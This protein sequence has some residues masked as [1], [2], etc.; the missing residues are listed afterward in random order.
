MKTN[1]TIVISAVIIALALVFSGLSI[2]SAISL[3][4]VNIDTATGK[5]LLMNEAEASE[6]IGIEV[7]AFNN[8]LKEDIKERTNLNVYPTYKFVPYMVIEGNKYFN[9]IELD[10]WVEFNMNNK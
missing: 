9:K 8:I 5:N 3:T 7:D 4:N 2:S 1:V 10:K 6:Y